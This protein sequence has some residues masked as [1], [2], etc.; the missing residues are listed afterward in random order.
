MINGCFGEI[1]ELLFEIEL[2]AVDGEKIA[3]EVLLDTGFTVGLL[4]LHTQDIESLGWSKI[5][6]ERAIQTAGGAEFFDIY[7]G[8]IILDE[9]EY[10]IPVLAGE[11]LPE[12]L[13]GLQW[14]KFLPLAVNFSRELLTLGE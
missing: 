3:V 5:D 13:L 8:K 11:N 6:S 4:A 12:S 1:G 9:I 2:V 10:E 14:L 7:A